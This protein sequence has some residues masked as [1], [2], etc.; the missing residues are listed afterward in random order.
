[1]RST[2]ELYYENTLKFELTL[3]ARNL[4]SNEGAYEMLETMRDAVCGKRLDQSSDITIPLRDD[5]V[6][7]GE[8]VFAYSLIVSVPVVIV[9]GRD[10]EPGPYLKEPIG[11]RVT[12]V[13]FVEE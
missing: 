9:Q 7:Y 2:S 6:D 12:H 3:R 1:M 5:F 10:F 11:G 8:G 4:R 13:T